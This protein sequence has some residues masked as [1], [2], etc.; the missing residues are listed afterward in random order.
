MDAGRTLLWGHLVG[1]LLLVAW[2]PFDSA[3]PS[4]P[5]M[6]AGAGAGLFG[7]AG[8]FF[9]Y[10]GLARGRA[11]VVAPTAAVV[12]AV[13]PVVFGLLSGDSPGLAGWVGVVVALPAIYLVSQ[14]EGSGRRAAGLGH[15]LAAGSLFG[16]Y[17]VLLALASGETGMWPLLASRALTAV[18][19]AVVAL[20]TKRQWLRP[21]TGGTAAAVFG[22]GA[23]DLVGN[24]GYLLAAAVGNLVV[25][26]VV[27]SFYPAVTVALAKVVHNESLSTPQMAGVLLA[28]V[29]VASFSIP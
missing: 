8:L 11:A 13:V 25:V 14:V 5:T 2:A 22:V 15:G 24:I 20:V 23:L 26:A 19:L 16:G 12:G 7:L 3:E 18:L 9:L 27:A 1:F 10:T 6:A 21:P 4:V 17:F 28:L 29:S